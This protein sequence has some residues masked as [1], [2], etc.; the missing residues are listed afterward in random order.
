MVLLQMLG[1]PVHS[2][3]LHMIFMLNPLLLLDTVQRQQIHIK[4][5]CRIKGHQDKLFKDNS[6]GWMHPRQANWKLAT[7]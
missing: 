1:L 3:F 4:R 7:V 5:G 2:R 6:V